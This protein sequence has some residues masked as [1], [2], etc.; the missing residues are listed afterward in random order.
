MQTSASERLLLPAMDLLVPKGRRPRFHVHLS[1]EDLTNVP[2]VSGLVH[3]RWHLR[4]SIR[5]E[6]RGKTDRS[7]IKDHKVQWSSAHRWPVRLHIDR[8]GRLNDAWLDF[9]VYQELY[10]GKERHALGK[11]SLNLAEYAGVREEVNRR[12][13]LQDSKVNST[14]LVA[15]YMQQVSGD[16]DFVAPELKK[17]QVFGGI[18]GL[19]TEGMDI[20]K[21]EEEL[22]YHASSEVRP[23]TMTNNVS[24]ELYRNSLSRRWQ[25]LAGELDPDDVVDDIFKGGDG[26][27]H[28]SD[29]DA[30]G[31]VITR[32]GPKGNWR[33]R[34]GDGAGRAGHRSGRREHNGLDSESSESDDDDYDFD[35]ASDRQHSR[36]SSSRRDLSRPTTGQS[37]RTIGHRSYNSRR[38]QDH[39]QHRQQGHRSGQVK[40]TAASRPLL[41]SGGGG[42][43][44]WARNPSMQR[45]NILRFDRG[46]NDADD[47][48]RGVS[49]HIDPARV[50]RHAGKSR[51][52]RDEMMQAAEAIDRT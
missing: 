28:A 24:V 27:L 1:I 15:I 5:G 3:V 49:W 26:F 36:P 8:T 14:L 20:K 42:G 16:R 25:A 31:Q 35:D 23:D 18:T 41:G 45:E 30:S 34:Y 4:D 38:Q 10:Q 43:G 21:R 22:G 29:V 39:H 48:L 6:A 9:D 46:S 47:I 7:I 11:L 40:G 17:A 51:E 19:L 2:L 32:R 37:D 50:S 12:Y 33:E 52:E 13:L 44:V